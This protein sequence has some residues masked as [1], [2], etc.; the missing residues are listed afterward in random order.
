MNPAWNF[1]ADD[2]PEHWETG[3]REQRVGILRHWRATDLAQARERLAAA[4]KT[5]SADLRQAFLGVVV[6]TLGEAD[7]AFLETILDDRS[8]EVRTR[9][10]ELLRRLPK[11]AFAARMTARAVPLL[12]FQPG[13]LLRRPTLEVQLPAEPDAPGKRD[14]LD[15]RAFGLYH[16]EFGDRAI[17]LIQILAATPLTHWTDTFGQPP[18]VL[19][20][21]LGKQEFAPA[22]ATGWALAAILQKDP[23]WASALLDGPVQPA[24]SFLAFGGLFAALSESAQIEK[25]RAAARDGTI[26]LDPSRSNAA[27]ALF[28]QFASARRELPPELSRAMLACLRRIAD[29][30]PDGQ[31]PPRLDGLATALALKMPPVLLPEALAGWSADKPRPTRMIPL[32]DF[33]REA[34]AALTQP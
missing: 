29:E 25:L 10:A 11:S 7:D 13:G 15:P 32:L 18:D 30:S 24:S 2:S 5:E 19:L 14:G 33:R 28:V 22:A 21:A 8:K 3:G 31:W 4:W 1:A 9:A 12:T 34:L 6:E 27:A 16:K 26:G 20:K 23:L 17:G